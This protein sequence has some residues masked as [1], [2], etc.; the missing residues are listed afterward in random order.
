M[1]NKPMKAPNEIWIEW[2]PPEREGQIVPSVIWRHSPLNDSI[3]DDIRYIRDDTLHAPSYYKGY[4]AN[5]KDYDAVWADLGKAIDMVR[6]LDESLSSAYRQTN[7]MVDLRIEH[8]LA[9]TKEFLK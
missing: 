2:C 1:Q 5:K 8:V 9:K 7:D 4:D 3:T 6:E